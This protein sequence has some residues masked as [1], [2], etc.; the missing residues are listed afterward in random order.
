IENEIIDCLLI[1]SRI[2]AEPK[3]INGDGIVARLSDRFLKFPFI[4]L[5]VVSSEVLLRNKVD[6]D[7]VYEKQKF[8]KVDSDDSRLYVQKI[9]NNINQYKNG[10]IELKKERKELEDA[11]HKLNDSKPNLQE[12]VMEAYSKLWSLD[13]KQSLYDGF[14]VENP[15]SNT[16]K[17][18]LE[19]LSDVFSRVEDE[20]KRIKNV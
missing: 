18:S 6:P 16:I 8:T 19:N 5:T 14:Q 2:V 4:V 13:M 15:S 10:L 9:F 20:L 11:V 7:K 3:L 1:D 17:E 12:D